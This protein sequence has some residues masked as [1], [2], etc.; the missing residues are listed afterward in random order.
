MG[1][2]KKMALASFFSLEKKFQKYPELLAKYKAVFDDYIEL[3]HMI[4]IKNPNPEEGYY[5]PHHAINYL[6]GSKGKFRPVFNGSAPTS[7]GVSFNKQQLPGPKLQRDLSETFITFRMSEFAATGDVTQMYRQVWIHPDEYKYQK[8]FWRASPNDELKVYAITVV[9]WVMTSAGFNAVR[10]MRQ[11]AI[12]E[13]ANF[14]LG[15]KIVLN[16]FYFDDML[17]GAD[18]EEELFEGYS[19]VTQLLKTGGFELKKLVTSSSK[20]RSVTADDSIQVLPSECKVLGMIWDPTGE[21]LRLMIG[22]LTC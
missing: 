6:P 8:V 11:C 7:N 5:L 9:S 2:S 14:S 1:N 21:R 12:D 18:S 10:A 13:E 20:L 3:G 16:N 22:N 19:E 15:S 4:E 17:Y